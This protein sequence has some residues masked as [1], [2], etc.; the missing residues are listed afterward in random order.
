MQRQRN[1]YNTISTYHI[2][3]HGFGFW[4]K[5][6]GKASGVFFFGSVKRMC[7]ITQSQ[8]QVPCHVL[9]CY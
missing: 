8:L 6:K 7:T 2:G 3:V 1:M 5:D 4:T 9:D